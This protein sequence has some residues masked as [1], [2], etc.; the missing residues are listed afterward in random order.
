MGAFYL[1]VEW[2]VVK[3]NLIPFDFLGKKEASHIIKV[4][5]R[6][7]I[8]YSRIQETLQTEENISKTQQDCLPLPIMRNTTLSI[9]CHIGSQ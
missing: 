9:T 5:E 2:Q 6:V 8:F 3:K 4:G 7:I 1:L